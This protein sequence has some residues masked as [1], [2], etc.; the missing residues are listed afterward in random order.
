MSDS[1]YTTTA[2]DNTVVAIEKGDKIT[3]IGGRPCELYV[4]E[5]APYAQGMVPKPKILAPV[6]VTLNKF[7]G[8]E[9]L[10]FKPVYMAGKT[11]RAQV[12]TEKANRWSKER[13]TNAPESKEKLYFNNANANQDFG[14]FYCCGADELDGL[15]VAGL[16]IVKLVNHIIIGGDIAAETPGDSDDQIKDINPIYL[17]LSNQYDY[18]GLGQK[19]L[20][21]NA[22]MVMR[23]GQVTQ[24]E[25]EN[26]S[27][28]SITVPDGAEQQYQIWDTN[29]I[30]H[31]QTYHTTIYLKR[32]K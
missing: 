17:S 25:I 26:A 11:L 6:N 5:V 16:F 10:T 3:S 8:I 1:T 28:I 32:T 29:G 18:D 31:E 12:K 30:R 21:G 24:A 14:V 20:C 23:S 19:T 7:S 15:F 4:N 9:P 27:Y 13:G 22:K 2:T